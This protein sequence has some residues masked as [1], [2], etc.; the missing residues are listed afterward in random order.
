MAGAGDYAA[1]YGTINSE[2]PQIVLVQPSGAEIRQ[3][4]ATGTRASAI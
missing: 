3:L 1:F 4:D 2:R